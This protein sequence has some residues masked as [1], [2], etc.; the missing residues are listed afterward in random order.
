MKAE[1]KHGSRKGQL[2]LR[3]LVIV[4]VSLFLGIT[5]YT[6]NAKRVMRNLLPM[7]F[8]VGAAVV[9]SGSMEPTL[10]VNDF[11]LVK[12]CEDYAVDDVVVYQSDRE[13]VIHRIVGIDGS[14]LVTK[15]DA[16]NIED[17]P[18]DVS[19]VKGKLV[20]TIPWIGLLIRGLQ[21]L[22][23]I[24]IVLTLAVFLTRLSWQKE[25]DAKRKE[26]ERIKEEIRRLR[27]EIESQAAENGSNGLNSDNS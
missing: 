23:G 27:T 11:V 2:L 10:S 3:I 4:F 19:S 6:I 5:V 8:G 25:K 16:N 12:A 18:I 9:L 24:L 22:P 1:K 7:P 20:L 13:L 14:S 26:Q 15:G 17:D 21:T